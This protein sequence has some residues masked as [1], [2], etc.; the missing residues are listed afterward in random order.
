MV[1]VN[2]TE[3]LT[4]E[5]SN[6]A[7]SASVKVAK[8]VPPLISGSTV[9]SV[10]TPEELAPLAVARLACPA[11]ALPITVSDAGLFPTAIAVAGCNVPSPFPNSTLAVESLPLATATS[12]L[13]SPLK[14]ATTRDP[15]LLPTR[16]GTAAWNVPSPLPFSTA[17]VLSVDRETIRSRREPVKFP[18]AIED[19]L[20]PSASEVPALNLPDPSPSSTVPEP[21]DR[22]EASAPQRFATTM[23]RFLSPLMSPTAREIGE[24]PTG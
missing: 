1:A 24:K 21:A 8:S 18:S 13:P 6:P 16:Y 5:G 14:S 22:H 9:N 12:A 11:V 10:P 3:S 7:V 4:F 17:T 20:F 19:G 23:S 15:G 2:V